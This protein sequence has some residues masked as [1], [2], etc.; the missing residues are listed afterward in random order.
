MS[1]YLDDD[2]NIVVPTAA[3]RPLGTLMPPQL[4]KQPTVGGLP[5]EWATAYECELPLSVQYDEQAGCWA[6]FNAPERSGRPFVGENFGGNTT[7]ARQCVLYGLCRAC[8]TP[9]RGAAW[10]SLQQSYQLGPPPTA[11]EPPYCW[12][13]LR[14]LLSVRKVDVGG[15]VPLYQAFSY[16]PYARKLCFVQ[17]DDAHGFGVDLEVECVRRGGVVAVPWALLTEWSRWSLEEVLAHTTEP[18]AGER[19]VGAFGFPRA[20]TAEQA[21]WLESEDSDDV[22][23]HDLRLPGNYLV[24]PEW[25]QGLVP[26]NVPPSRH[27]QRPGTPRR[28]LRPRRKF[29]HP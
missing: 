7:R 13:C 27:A 2:G 9:I 24:W 10:V 15:V 22:G 23:L 16:V 6:L 28:R 11:W 20:F 12:E 8:G 14:Y 5:V 19:S 18:T 17:P 29:Y 25:R 21:E 1:A 4:A 26:E 3:T